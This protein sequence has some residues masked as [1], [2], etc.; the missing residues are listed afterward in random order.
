MED[1][2]SGFP[3]D[4]RVFPWGTTLAAVLAKLNLPI[5]DAPA[6][7]Y[8]TGGASCAAAFGFDTLGVEITAAGSTRPVTGLCYELAPP[9]GAGLPGP[10]AWLAPL[11]RWLGRPDQAEDCPLPPH[12]DPAGCVRYHANWHRRGHSVAISLYGAL[13]DVGGGHSAGC[14][15][16]N[17][18]A[19]AAAAPF[20]DERLAAAADLAILAAVPV[21]M[22]K[23]T[24]ILEQQ[25]HYRDDADYALSTPHLLPTPKTIKAGLGPHSFALCRI[26][27]GRR[28]CLSTRWDSIVFEIGQ[29]VVVNWY[30]VLPAKG[31]GSSEIEVD[32]WSVRDVAGSRVI[33]E[34]LA[35]LGAMAGVEVR[36]EQSYDC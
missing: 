32:G 29:P 17:W 21:D 12:G 33:A 26:G 30:D 20:L 15:W 24:L 18:S 31:G 23:F 27:G 35:V 25:P 1:L 16:L 7:G 4:G 11:T 8:H 36:H 6:I 14:L 5:G 10:A 3:I 9:A 28:W 22:R 2:A 19:A 34:A 13:R